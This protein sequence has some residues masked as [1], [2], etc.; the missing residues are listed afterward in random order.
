MQLYDLIKSLP[1]LKVLRLCLNC[2]FG[3]QQITPAH[4]QLQSCSIE[5][6]QFTVHNSDDIKGL[7]YLKHFAAVFTSVKKIKIYQ[8]NANVLNEE[9]VQTQF[10][11]AFGKHKVKVL[12]SIVPQEAVKVLFANTCWKV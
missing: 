7:K 4:I 3:P 5:E 6:I 11:S 12:N 1:T 8:M 2:F 10:E 9:Q